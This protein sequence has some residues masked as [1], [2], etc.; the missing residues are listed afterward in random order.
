[1][2]LS[3]LFTAVS[4]APKEH[5]DAQKQ[6]LNK[7]MTEVHRQEKKIFGDGFK[8]RDFETGLKRLAGGAAQGSSEEEAW[9]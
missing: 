2:G 8:M 7:G 3:A 6:Y 5:M 1:M 9:I 4:T